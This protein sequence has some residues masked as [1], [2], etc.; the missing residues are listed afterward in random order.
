MLTNLTI[1]NFK[2]HNET[3]LKLG[4]L[5]VLTGMNGMGKSSVIQSLLLLRQSLLSNDL[6]EGMNLNGELFSAGMTDDIRGQESNSETLDISF[7]FE[8]QKSLDFSFQYPSNIS[9]STMLLGEKSNVTSKE[10]LSRY[11]L[12][13]NNFQYISAFRLGPQSSYKRNT[14]SVKH[15]QQISKEYGQCEYVVHYLD[16]FKDEEIPIK[17]LASLKTDMYYPDFRLKTQVELWLREISPNIKINIEHASEELKLKYRFDREGEFKTNEFSAI[18]TGFGVTYALPILVAILSARKDSLIII[19]NPESHIHPGGQAALMQ[20][21]SKAVANGVQ[22]VIETHSDHIVNGALVAV[23]QKM[24]SPE[25]LSVYYFDRDEE[26]HTAIAHHLDVSPTGRIKNPPKGFFD[27][28][29]M[30]L[31]VLV[32]I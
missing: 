9:Y 25:Q 12:F 17:E 4:G 23:K 11:S 3:Y 32:G 8:G 2:L 22:V 5:V 31:R 13:N 20:L 29:R 30:D 16:E 21:I 7:S 27:Q 15:R 1:K 24:I 14:S 19:E 26:K 28:M 18:N 10:V 6:S